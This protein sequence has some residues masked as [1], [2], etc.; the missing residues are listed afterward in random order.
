[1]KGVG[2]AGVS[3]TGKRELARAYA[4]ETGHVLVP[5][6]SGDLLS[7]TRTKFTTAG[8]IKGYMG[9]LVQLEFAY[10]SASSRFVTDTTPI[11]VMAELYSTFT[12][13]N[14]PSEEIDGQID[15]LWAYARNICSKYLIVIMHIKPLKAGARREHLTALGAGLIHTRLVN[16]AATKLFTV[17]RNMVDLGKRLAALKSFVFNSYE[18]ESPYKT[19]SSLRN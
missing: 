18:E 10:L 7:G 2:I 11:D 4:A 8:V 1:M 19:T 6:D 9:A 17:N 13:F 15:E 5:I 3:G 12:W 16:E 14:E